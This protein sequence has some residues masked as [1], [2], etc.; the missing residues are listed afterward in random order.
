MQANI[1]R[2]RLRT[3]E[4]AAR[5]HPTKWPAIED[6]RIPKS[7]LTP[8]I[9][10][11]Q[12]RQASGDLTGIAQSESTKLIAQEWKDLSDA[13]KQVCRMVW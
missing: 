11:F 13:S 12:E 2:R 7:P 5:N 6:G 4:N 10:F 8:Y 1:A 9:Q 3:R